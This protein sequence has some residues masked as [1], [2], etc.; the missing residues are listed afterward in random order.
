M[1]ALSH[2]RACS[3]FHRRVLASLTL[4]ATIASLA[5]SF[6][7]APAA[8]ASGVALTAGAS[9]WA[10]AGVARTHASITAQRQAKL[11]IRPPSSARATSLRGVRGPRSFTHNVPSPMMS[12]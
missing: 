8:G 11:D 6:T 2:R 10:K 9:F 7:V 4:L 1:T 12:W 3:F 5:V